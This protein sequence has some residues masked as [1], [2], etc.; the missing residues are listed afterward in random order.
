M[1]TTHQ[2]RL[3]FE[4]G[5]PISIT[6]GA[7]EDVITAALRQGV[8]LVSDCRQGICAACRGFL[9]EGSYDDLLPHSP[10]ALTE[11]EEEEGWVLACRLRP[12]SD[13]HVDFDYPADRVARWDSARRNGSII[14]AEQVSADVIRL[15]VATLAAQAPLHWEAGQHVRL[16]LVE[17]GIARAC[18]IANLA[19]ASRHLEFFI[20]LVPGDAFS[21]ALGAGSAEGRIVEIEGPFGEFTLCDGEH[22][23]VFVAVGTGLGPVLAMLRQVAAERDAGASLIFEVKGE[24]DLF[25]ERDLAALTAASPGIEIIITVV[26]PGASWRGRR[27]TAIDVLTESLARQPDP[28]RRGYYLCGP[29]PTVAAARCVIEQFGVPPTAIR[30]EAL[31][32]SEGIR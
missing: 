31:T 1:R 8:L 24:A 28:R 5:D 32:S 23:A 17:Q 7:D 6:C 2:V 22:D 3:S 12:R 25:A 20:S 30:Q 4:G 18:S 11:R 9:E 13:L 26:Q 14:V 15:V 27:G 16:R 29:E 10:H 19:S 21:D